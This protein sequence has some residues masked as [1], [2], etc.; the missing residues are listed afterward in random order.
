MPKLTKMV[1]SAMKLPSWS[2]FLAKLDLFSW[3]VLFPHFRPSD[4]TRGNSFFQMSSYAHANVCITNEKNKK[5]IPMRASHGLKWQN[6]M[7]KLKSSIL[8]EEEA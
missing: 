8:R 5:K 1:S 2:E 7:Y 4:A 3:Y 6:K